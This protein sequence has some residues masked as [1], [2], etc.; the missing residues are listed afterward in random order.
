M[1]VADGVAVGLGVGDA[2]GVRVGD[3]VTFTSAGVIDGGGTSS[4]SCVAWHARATVAMVAT[5]AHSISVACREF[6]LGVAF[7]GMQTKFEV[8]R[9]LARA[10]GLY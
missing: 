8:L 10:E 5:M 1:A 9:G 3:G 4:G 2:T 6:I 7:R